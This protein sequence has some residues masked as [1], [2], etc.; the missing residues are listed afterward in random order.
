MRVLL[1]QERGAG[2]LEFALAAPVLFT[3][4]IGATQVGTMFYANAGVQNAVAEGAR[5]ASIFPLP[6]DEEIKAA[7]TAQDFG[8]DAG[9][10]AGEPVVEHRVDDDGNAVADISLSY[11]V[12]L[13]F[14]F[15]NAGPVMINHSRSVFVQTGT[16]FMS[17]GDSGGSS[18][19]G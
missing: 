9:E 15:F 3:I 7:I 11:E 18:G 2:A 8:L 12:P 1:K 6:S 10:L 13:D 4:L 19:G 14:V 16:E 17:E 5:V